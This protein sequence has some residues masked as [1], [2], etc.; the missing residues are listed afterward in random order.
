MA[1][2]SDSGLADALEITPAMLEAGA[3]TLA[4]F[5]QFQDERVLASLVYRAME[6]ARS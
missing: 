1:E 3:E 5:A 2:V 6:L 4:E